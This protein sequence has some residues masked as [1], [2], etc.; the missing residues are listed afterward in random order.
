MDLDELAR[1]IRD[2]CLDQDGFLVRLH[3]YSR[4]DEERYRHLVE[5]ISMYADLLSDNDTINRSVAG[6]LFELM[7]ALTTALDSF[8][9]LGHADLEKVQ[10]AHAELDELLHNKIF[11][12]LPGGT[13]GNPTGTK[14]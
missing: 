1:E 5:N 10:R 7:S 8:D 4:F 12:V 13:V 6:C 2:E 14:C 11:F 9:M 3:S